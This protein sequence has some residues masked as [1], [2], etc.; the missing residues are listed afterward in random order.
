MTGPGGGA[1][2]FQRALAGEAHWSGY[3]G[4]E[5]ER[6]CCARD[7][8]GTHMRSGGETSFRFAVK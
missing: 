6:R 3:R 1:F 5:P 4:G 2:F 8:S 7:V